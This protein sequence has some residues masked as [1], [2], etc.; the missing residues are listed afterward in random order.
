[1]NKL[2]KTGIII[3]SVAFSLYA[4]FLLLPLILSPI[5][6]SYNGQISSMLEEASGYKVQLEKLGVVTTPK[7][8]AGIRVGH[9]EFAIP[10]GETFLV[11]DKFNAKLSLLP[12]LIGRIEADSISVDNVKADLKVRPDGHFLIEE[13]LPQ[14][15]P[16]KSA[17]TIQ[18]L[19]LGIKL[20]NH[21]PNITIKEYEFNFIDMQS[22]ANYSI[23]GENFKISDFILDKKIKLFAKGKMTLNKLEQFNF[24]IKFVNRLMPNLSLNDL[25]FNPEPAN[26]AT[27][28]QPIEFNIIDLFK[29]LNKSELSA[30]LVAN[31]HTSGTLETPKFYGFA[32][33]DN[34]TMLVDGKKL[35]AGRVALNAKHD[36]LK[37]NLDVYSAD[38]QKTSLIGKFKTGKHPNIDMQ[39]ISNAQFNDI[40]RII[41]TFAKSFN[42]NDL[43][44]LT[45]TGG[46]DADFTLKTN[47][48]H[49]NSNGYFKIPSAN[50]K[51]DLYNVALN[52]ITADIDFNNRLNIKNIELE[53]LKQPLKIYGAIEKNSNTDVHIIADKLLLKGLIAAAG[54]LQI[55]KENCFN[56]GTLTLDAKL[57]GKLSKLIPSVDL[58]ID[59]LDITNNPSN[60][61]VTMPN[62][63]LV[64]N[65]DGKSFNGDVTTS[66]L[67]VVNPMATVS[68]PETAVT[69]GE[70]DINIQKAY[71]ILNNSRIDI[72]GK[73]TNYINDKIAIDLKADGAILANDIKS[74]I[75]VEMHSFVSGIGKLPLTVSVTGNTKV[76]DIALK[77]IANPSNYVS[78][79][80][81]DILK[82]KTTIINSDLRIAD[83]AIKLANTG[84]FADNLN[85]P[86]ISLIGAVNNLSS[87]QKLALRLSVP[88]RANIVIPGFKNSNLGFRGDV[89]ITGTAANPHLKGLINVPTITIPDMAITITNS[90]ANLNGP[91]LN[92]NAT[93][94]NFR[95]GGIIADNLA[96]EFSLKNYSILH[97][98]NLMGDAFNGK[99]SGNISYGINDG[100]ITVSMQGS[101][102]DAVKAIEGA[103]GIKNA[104]S[105]KLGFNADIAT[106]GV[107]DIDI[108]KN[109]T[110]KVSFD[111]SNGKFM[112]VGRFDNLLYA[113]NILGN[114]ILKA[115]V[116]SV[117][118]L[119][120]IQN[121]TEFKSI[122]GDMTFE[123]GW[124][125]ISSIKTSGPLMA[126]FINGRYN[127]LNGTANVVILGRLDA[128]VVALLGPLGD[129]SVEKLT[130]YIPKFGALTGNLINAMTSDPAKEN[131]ASIPSLSN[132]STN[133]K[134]FKVEFNGGLESSSS[135]KSFKWLSVCDT[136][137][138]D[139]KQ[140]ITNTVDN[141]KNSVQDAKQ[142]FQ[143]TKDALKN[144]IQDSKQQFK[145]A[146]ED[147]KN[148]FKF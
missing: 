117:T 99:I 63:K 20:S 118:N 81:T 9:A 103:A 58:A 86:V 116:T 129:L 134:D 29:A 68:V 38:N 16:D 107:T 42:Y 69:I 17:E 79:I 98:T 13:F 148:L 114:A 7:L 18:S 112:N 115:A 53:I 87:E 43:E 46:I 26:E 102:M 132:G 145:N 139:I 55:L 59:N 64:I 70:K 136:S 109:L 100:K 76:Q 85:N 50:I 41:N 146:K 15:D 110:G 10:T 27:A 126:Y 128:K 60:T 101:D 74:M 34:I 84:I 44:T 95:Y 8:T 82:G 21:L 96:S 37:L 97:I 39:F 88:K 57:S 140:D 125:K 49:V 137:E 56:S 65:T 108:M 14:T 1:M 28:Q 11:A 123:N 52:N 66:N 47:T 75:P 2:N 144:S 30:D 91:V 23:E 94:Q 92:G 143:D 12:L 135:V 73:I 51:Y 45:A 130:S 4:I 113:Q 54:Q 40:F 72:T 104:L 80:E 111:I 93:I 67:R 78:L 141:L 119:P 142:N 31:L 32:N 24:D 124:A 122:S 131:T 138:I 22:G 3:G 83:D 77:L 61:R 89:D 25:V 121:T 6:N 71:L 35:P 33:I 105:G 127:L 48:K 147:L 133:Y 106:E 120:L 90:I 5:L 19:P 62:A 36:K